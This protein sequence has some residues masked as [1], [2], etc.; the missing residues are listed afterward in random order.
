M[1]AAAAAALALS[2]LSPQ[3]PLGLASPHA[4]L[5][6]VSPPLRFA[7]PLLHARACC[8]LS[9][10]EVDEADADDGRRDVDGAL[11]RIAAPAL[12]G[13]AVEPVASLVDTAAIG[14]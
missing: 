13:L 7:S 10:A 4:A 12:V 9:A 1:L 8:R 2:A 5:L 6:P 14:R 11:L 3:P